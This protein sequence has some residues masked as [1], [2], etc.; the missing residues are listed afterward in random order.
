[1]E[2]NDKPMK[3]IGFIDKKYDILKELSSGGEGQVCSVLDKTTKKIYAAKFT[4]IQHKNIENEISIL[5]DLKEKGVK[6]VVEYVN[7][8]KAE[9]VFNN[10]KD[11]IKRYL[12]QELVKNR[13]LGDYIL[14]T[15][16]SF[17]ERHCK[18]LFFKIVKCIES[19]HE[20]G[21]C[22]RDLKLD[23]ILLDDDFDPKICDF[24]YATKNAEK[25]REGLGTLIYMAPEVINYKTYN[26]YMV[27]IFNLG[28]ILIGLV[29][30][31]YEFY[32]AESSNPIYKI[33]KAGKKDLFWMA[34]G[35][36]NNN[37]SDECK[38]LCFKMIAFNPKQRPSLKEILKHPWFGNIPQMKE[39]ELKNHEIEIELKKTLK[40]RLEFVN[41]SITI[42]A[43]FK[44][45]GSKKVI[46]RTGS[47][48]NESI[49]SPDAKPESIES[50][51]F[52]NYYF[53]IKGS[54]VPRDFMIS[55]C[56]QI[57][58]KFGMKN[59]FMEANK[60]NKLEFDL[61][62]SEKKE[63]SSEEEELSM[64]IA[65][66]KINDG[67]VLRFLRKEISKYDFIEKF[68]IISDLVK[69]LIE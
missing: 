8:G 5:K 27:D 31:K 23:N 9:I 53:Y 32:K 64:R 39:E 55:L 49:F 47:D 40:E 2:E 25:A 59:C 21:Y 18:V 46:T 12:I 34:F 19:I 14:Y 63:E 22:H 35:D 7:D 54:I 60:E 16:T 56:D 43:K 52:K 58:N 48:E 41:E 67:Y 10:K 36:V 42:H 69:K 50:I 57:N 11:D 66:Y 65:L 62:I 68:K 45:Y 15:Q 4:D 37:I 61:F 44:L 30:G 20:L 28:M 6:N 24:G 13:D 17:E 26:G 51:Y 3:I 38:D 29:T 1:M 33:I